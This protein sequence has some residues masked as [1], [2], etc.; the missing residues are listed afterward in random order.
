MSI[1]GECGRHVWENIEWTCAP[2]E[3][4]AGLKTGVEDTLSE[5]S[6]FRASTHLANQMKKTKSGI[7]QL[8]IVPGMFFEDMG[9]HLSADRWT[10]MMSENLQEALNE[11]ESV[12]D[13]AVLVHVLTKKGKGSEPAETP[14]GPIPRGRAL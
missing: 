6:G 2:H 14:S 10:G 11:G 1:C 12:S 5:D 8:F 9:D 13:R 4:Y 7:K 3:A